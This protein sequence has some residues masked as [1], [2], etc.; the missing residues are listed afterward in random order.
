MRSFAVYKLDIAFVESAQ[1]VVTSTRQLCLYIKNFV[2]FISLYS[3]ITNIVHFIYIRRHNVCTQHTHT[4][5]HNIHQIVTDKFLLLSR[6]S[7]FDDPKEE[8]NKPYS[9]VL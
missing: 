5:T 6:D 1:R 7:Y 8:F 2:L 3:R 9:T 4:H